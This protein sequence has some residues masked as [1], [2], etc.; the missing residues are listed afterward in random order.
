MI[1]E[2]EIHLSVLSIRR[3]RLRSHAEEIRKMKF[4]K[5]LKLY[6]ES[7]LN[8]KIIPA[9]AGY[10]LLG[11]DVNE[12]DVTVAFTNRSYSSSKPLESISRRESMNFIAYI[13][14]SEMALYNLRGIVAG[15]SH[16]E[17]GRKPKIGQTKIFI[18][19]LCKTGLFEGFKYTFWDR[20]LISK[21]MERRTTKIR[22]ETKDSPLVMKL[23]EE[24]IERIRAGL[25]LQA[26]I[27]YGSLCS[28][29]GFLMSW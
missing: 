22:F 1:G 7:F 19:E 15:S 2:K 13:I 9:G 28:G 11:L 12:K 3:R 21:R 4:L 18:D 14:K 17:N 25:L 26:F 24:K 23:K 8:R 6:E 5:P 27:E 16:I 20:K 29:D 10:G